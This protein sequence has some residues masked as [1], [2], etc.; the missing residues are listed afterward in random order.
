MGDL[1]RAVPAAHA[2][3]GEKR[4]ANP[5][6]GDAS[7]ERGY[8]NGVHPKRTDRADICAGVTIDQM[9]A[10]KIGQEAPLPSLEL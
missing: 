10:A 2:E 6:Q 7:S 3:H 8:L 1:Y 5:R 9:A 4:S